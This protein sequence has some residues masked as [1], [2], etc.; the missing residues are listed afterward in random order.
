[1]RFSR[2][3]AFAQFMTPYRSVSQARFTELFCKEKTTALHAIIRVLEES[4]VKTLRPIS[5]DICV[6]I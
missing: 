4:R 6:I 1:M 2:V 5:L 3:G